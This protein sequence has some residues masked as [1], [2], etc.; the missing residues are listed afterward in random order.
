MACAHLSAR[1]YEIVDRRFRTREGEVDIIAR[2]G[3]TTVFVEVKTRSGQTFGG[4]LDAVT[5]T[6]QARCCR[7]AMAY[8]QAND[9]WDAA[10]RF[11]VIG[12]V[13]GD[14][15]PTITHIENAFS[16]GDGL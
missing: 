7:A 16:C 5:P 13:T 8:L 10:C 11:D 3:E 1:G 4:P 12:I 6:K 9:L 14:G 2:D 15:E